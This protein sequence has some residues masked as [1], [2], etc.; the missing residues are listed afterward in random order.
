[1]IN[2]GHRFQV[3]IWFDALF[4]GTSINEADY[5]ASWSDRTAKIGPTDKKVP[6]RPCL[7]LPDKDVTMMKFIF[8]PHAVKLWVFFD[9]LLYRGNVSRPVSALTQIKME[10]SKR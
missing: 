3:L 5:I 8:L 1:M 6:F 2:P 4:V 9:V 10:K 7:W